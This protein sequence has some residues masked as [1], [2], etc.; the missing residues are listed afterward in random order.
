[1]TNHPAVSIWAQ[2]TSGISAAGHGAGTEELNFL[3]R[4]MPLVR[5]QGVTACAVLLTFSKQARR[6]T[7]NKTKIII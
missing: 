7:N 1:M 4:P 6:P 2:H 5:Q 3:E